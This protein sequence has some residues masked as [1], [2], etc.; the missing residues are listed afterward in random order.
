MIHYAHDPYVY[1][2]Y[3]M[4][5]ISVTRRVVIHGIMIHSVVMN[6]QCLVKNFNKT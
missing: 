1:D 3:F 6:E 2:S 4:I 5:H